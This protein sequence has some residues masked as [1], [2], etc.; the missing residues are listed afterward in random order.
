MV[1]LKEKDLLNDD[2]DYFDQ[3]LNDASTKCGSTVKSNYCG[4]S[5]DAPK[6]C[7]YIE[8]ANKSESSKE[9]NSYCLP[10]EKIA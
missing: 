1:A 4:L 2:V 3:I 6:R 5:R 9:K 10:T 8:V 7:K